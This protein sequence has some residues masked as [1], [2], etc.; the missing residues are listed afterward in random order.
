VQVPGADAKVVRDGLHA[1]E[2]LPAVE[3][4]AEVIDDLPLTSVPLR[5]GCLRILQIRLVEA[6]DGRPLAVRDR[7]SGTLVGVAN[8]LANQPAHL[9]IELGSIWY[10]R[11]AQRAAQA[12]HGRD[13]QAAQEEAVTSP[14]AAGCVGRRIV[15]R[16]VALLLVAVMAVLGGPVRAATLADRLNQLITDNSYLLT[17]A[18]FD[19]LTPAPQELDPAVA[20][21]G[22]ARDAG[23]RPAR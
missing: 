1:D 2:H 21:S 6:P 17:G 13:Q 18:N 3:C 22:E 7:A 15:E 23:D 11:I 4:G 5:G 9:K 10:G 19:S 8:F 12:V 16:P 14:A 20:A